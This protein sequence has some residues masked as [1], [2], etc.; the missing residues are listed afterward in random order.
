MWL[1]IKSTL[2]CT[3]RDGVREYFIS[4]SNSESPID[5]GVRPLARL[6]LCGPDDDC[7]TANRQS[8]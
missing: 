6:E 2:L 3:S 1:E 7:A 8:K 5:D 4:T